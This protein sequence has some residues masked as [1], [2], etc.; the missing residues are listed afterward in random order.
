MCRVRLLPDDVAG[1]VEAGITLLEAARSLGVEIPASCAG[2]GLCGKCRVRVL[3]GETERNVGHERALSPAELASGWRL[4]CLTPVTD[5]LVVEVPEQATRTAILTEFDETDVQPDSAIQVLP[6]ELSAP[7]L[8]DQVADMQRLS[9]GLGREIS[10][11]SC[12][13][14]IRN[15]P[16]V[17]RDNDWRVYAVMKDNDLLG[18]SPLADGPPPV[19]GLAVDVG[20]TT[21]AGVLVDRKSVV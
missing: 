2:K 1:D 4:A 17:L 9:R 20:T 10:P 13:E 21:V 6:V 14:G 16:D 7:T 18:V 5:N 8:K 12:I 11:D 3:E 15:L 19:M